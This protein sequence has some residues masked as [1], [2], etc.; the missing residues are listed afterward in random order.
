VGDA[1]GRVLVVC[2]GNVCRSPFIQLVLQRELDARRPEGEPG[3]TVSSAGTGALAGQ[4][5]DARAAAQAAALGLDH[6][7]FLARQLTPAMVA[8]AD[9]V[10][11]ATRRHRGDVATLH[12]RALRYVF[13]LRDFA[14]LASAH[15]DLGE[16]EAAPPQSR[17]RLQ[18][19]VRAVAARRGVEPPLE[20]SHADVVDPFR[21]EDELFV[22]MARQ[23]TDA[24][25]VV[26]AALAV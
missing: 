17:A 14:D 22:R 26:A 18:S 15:L 3:I 16:L 6:S 20:A 23:V 24:M 5:M 21:R 19:V 11:T 13:T 10:L 12:P 4:G 9:L 8:E 2:T 25:P 1:G 7:G